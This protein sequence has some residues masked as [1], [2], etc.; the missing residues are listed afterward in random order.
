ME[1]AHETGLASRITAI[2]L[3]LCGGAPA[4]SS[5]TVLK[6]W[7]FRNS[8]HANKYKSSKENSK[9][10]IHWLLPT[11]LLSMQCC[12]W[13]T[14]V[15]HNTFVFFFSLHWEQVIVLMGLCVT[16]SPLHRA[17][18]AETLSWALGVRFECV[19]GS[20]IFTQLLFSVPNLFKVFSLKCFYC[21]RSNFQ[22]SWPLNLISL[23]WFLLRKLTS[24]VAPGRNWCD[25]RQTWSLSFLAKLCASCVWKTNLSSLWLLWYLPWSPAIYNT[26]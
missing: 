8:W 21:W 12:F 1:P 15:L 11:Q 3:C 9:C 5:V 24:W 20:V 4:S 2:T 17:L 6:C 16:H 10:W 13:H 26:D 19:W 18:S 22:V 23:V 7:L 14:A 25:R